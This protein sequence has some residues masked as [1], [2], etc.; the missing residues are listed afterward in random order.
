MSDKNETNKYKAISA[1]RTLYYAE[2]ITETESDKIK[3]KI[4]K[5]KD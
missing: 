1:W 5:I 4:Q 3:A 2:L